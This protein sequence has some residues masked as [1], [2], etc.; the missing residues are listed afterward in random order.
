MW[1]IKRA[2]QEAQTSDGFETI[3]REL[4]LHENETKVLECLGRIQG[5][6]PVYLPQSHAFTWKIVEAHLATLHGGVGMTMARIRERF[7]IL[8]LRSLVKRVRSKC[9]WCVRFRTQAYSKPPPGN[10]PLSRTKGSTP[11]QV[12]GVDF[13]G[14]IR[15]QAKARTEKKAYLVLY[16]CS[17]TRAVHLDLL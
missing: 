14:P 6:Y 10:L 4:N 7:W 5:E 11:F 2:Q 8:K 1:W 16:G 12:L 13:A 9:H 17:L 3:K 15:Y